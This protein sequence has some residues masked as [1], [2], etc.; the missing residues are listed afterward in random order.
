[1]TATTLPANPPVEEKP[2]ACPAW[3]PW[4]TAL[5]GV[6][7]TSA[8]F[9]VPTVVAFIAAVLLTIAHGPSAHHFL[10]DL[11]HNG[12]FISVSTIASALLGFLLIFV[13]VGMRRHLYPDVTLRQYLRLNRPSGR[14]PV[15]AWFGILALYLLAMDGL[16]YA[17]GRPIV[18]EFAVKAYLTAVFP[19]LLWLAVV[20]AAPLFEEA[21]FRGFLLEGYRKTRRRTLVAAVILS[22]VWAG[23]HLQYG[24]YEM[25]W[26][27]GLGLILCAARL[28]TRSLWT[29]IA[30]HTF[31]NLVATIETAIVATQ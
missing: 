1:M 30:M 15:L 2:P 6:F 27:F 22:A 17:L 20:A 25:A 8:F 29:P 16:S 14:R 18:P 13:A 5:L 3:G 31:C 21:L 10:A 4:V 26:I 7:I 12:L 11:E 19:P 24:L 28:K 23:I 9:V